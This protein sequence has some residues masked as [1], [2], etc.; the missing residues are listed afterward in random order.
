MVQYTA[1]TSKGDI[2]QEYVFNEPFRLNSVKNAQ[3]TAD[4]V[5]ENLTDSQTKVVWT[6]VVA[7]S[8]K[9]FNAA[10][11]ELTGGTVAEDGTISNKPVGA[12]K[13]AYKYDNVVIPQNDLPVLNARMENIPLLAKA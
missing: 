8:A 3:Y 12:V 10:G 6:P 1:G 9:F 13:V 2:D 7:D 11:E 4:S 5:V